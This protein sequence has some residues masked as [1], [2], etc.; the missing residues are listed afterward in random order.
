MGRGVATLAGERHP[1][2][3]K[4]AGHEVL[5]ELGRGGMGVVYRVRS[6]DGR[7]AALKLILGASEGTLARFE[8]ER[9]LLASL[10][11]DQGFVGLLD[12]RSSP[13]GAWLL[14]PLV[15]GGTL[16]KRL[17]AGPLGVEETIALGIQLATALGKAHER[18][19]VHRDVKPENVLFAASGRPL[20]ADL[21]LAKHFDRGAKGA[22]QSLSLTQQGAYKGTAGYMA[23]EQL[24]D[25]KG[26]GPRADVF[27]LGA[28]LHECLA[29]RPAFRG[30]D[31][32]EVLAKLSAGAFEPLDRPDA[33]RWLERVL[34]KALALDPEARFADGAGLA[35][36]LLGRERQPRELLASA[37]P[38]P[39][40]TRLV[41]GVATGAV[42][43]TGVLM[44]LGGSALAPRK[45]TPPPPWPAPSPEP[46]VTVEPLPDGLRL[47]GRTVPAADAKEVSLYLFRL[48]DG[49]DM[50]MV[51][52]PSGEFIMGA[53]GADAF[54]EKPR[55]KHLLAR[56][57]WLGR[58]DV[59]WAQYLGFCV[60]GAHE[61]PARPVWWNGVPG[62]KEDHPVVMVSWED[63]RDYCRWAKLELPDEVEWEKAAR[64]TDGRTWPWGN[65]WDP[66]ARCNFA[67]ASCPLDGIDVVGGKKASEAFKEQGWKWDRDH[68]DGYAFSSP[69]GS[70]PAGVSPC[71][72]LDMAGN[73]Y[74]WC[75]DWFDE[76][77]YVRYAQRDPSPAEG[78]LRVSRGGSWLDDERHCRSSFRER[79]APGFRN[80]YLGFRVCLRSVR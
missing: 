63:A 70:Y 80:D 69:V 29:G 42:V 41:V 36:A 53:D 66:G 2:P 47:A 19:I 11:E 77:A 14:M 32:L 61:E 22:S 64:G 21:G 15:P 18:G 3:V 58:D 75:E 28:V 62:P 23:P 73:V 30:N 17:E 34:M 45:A 27:A 9:R 7:E 52:V 1:G 71:G 46:A 78:S 37:K 54:A 59:T 48:P 31:V 44:A 20:V 43:L 79:Y 51:E 74:Q 67:D 50:K 49:S 68:Q 8:R 65:E 35:R 33:P 56:R 60:A 39:A 26:V 5:G 13:E 10:G 6:P 55:H 12:A 38:R 40:W 57:C 25:A 16:R 72:A 24:E 76:K 4:I